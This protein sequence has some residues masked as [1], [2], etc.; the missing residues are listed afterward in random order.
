MVSKK[1][2]GFCLSDSTKSAIVT[3]LMRAV[4]NS[5]QQAVVS[6]KEGETLPLEGEQYD[7]DDEFVEAGLDIDE[8]SLCDWVVMPSTLLLKPMQLPHSQQRERRF[9]AA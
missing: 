8:A 9:T 2:V 7:V 1:R 6:V 4:F 3:S 5:C